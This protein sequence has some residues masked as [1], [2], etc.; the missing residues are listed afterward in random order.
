MRLVLWVLTVVAL[1]EA[2]LWV[3]RSR[4]AFPPCSRH[5]PMNSSQP[6][7]LCFGEG[8]CL[9]LVLGLVQG[10]S[11]PAAASFPPFESRSSGDNPAILP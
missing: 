3:P 6:C 1:Q 10:S 4:P 11:D 8:D 2:V 5:V 9:L 7:S